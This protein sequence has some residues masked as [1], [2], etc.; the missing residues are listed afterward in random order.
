MKTEILIILTLTLL[1]V[2]PSQ[3]QARATSNEVIK[4]R[5][6]RQTGAV[7]LPAFYFKQKAREQERRR[8]LYLLR[9]RQ[10]GLAKPS[11][12]LDEQPYFGGTFFKTLL[13]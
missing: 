5:A 2:I 1:V 6:K 10:Q 3:A 11:I 12:N 9:L 13:Y 7:F 8:K 4:S